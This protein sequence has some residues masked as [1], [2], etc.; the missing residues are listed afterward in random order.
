MAGTKA[1]ALLVLRSYR[2]RGVVVGYDAK[3]EMSERWMRRMNVDE[4]R[5]ASWLLGLPW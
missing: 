4:L 5:G 2:Y 1:G 3:C